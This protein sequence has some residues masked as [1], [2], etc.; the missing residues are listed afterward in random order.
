MGE[1]YRARDT[2]L[3][4]DVALKVLPDQFI[5]DHDRLARFQ[6]EAEVLA[7]LNHAR[8]ASIYG[9]EEANGVQALVLEMV[10]G[11]TLADRIALGPIPLDEA[12]P[13]SSQ[14]A[15][16]LEAAHEHGVI[17]RDLK[18]GNI[19]VLP[20]GSVKVLDFGLA[21]VLDP[22]VDGSGHSQSPTITSPAMTRIG[23]VLGTAAYMSPEQARGRGVDKRSDIWAFG[24]VLYEMLTGS[25]AFEGG[26]VSDTL[27]F[28]ITKEPDWSALP[29]GLPPAVARSVASVP[30]EKRTPPAARYWRRPARD[31]R[32]AG[33]ARRWYARGFTRRRRADTRSQGAS[34]DLPPSRR[35]YGDRFDPGIDATTP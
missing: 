11:P 16:A 5:A 28:V 32:R 30:A 29:S 3:K 24:C 22:D 2:K 27:A 1:V 26:E 14:I 18:P 33:P 7:S 4:R 35:A 6:R 23:V 15:D 31:R 13:I 21:K 17:H 12:L 8:I 19:K 20:D 9:V 10:E 34:L 25:R